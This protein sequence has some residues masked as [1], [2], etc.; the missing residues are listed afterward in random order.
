MFKKRL[1]KPAF[2]EFKSLLGINDADGYAVQNDAPNMRQL[3]ESFFSFLDKM[4]GKYE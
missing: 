3:K 2:D 1:R 4:D